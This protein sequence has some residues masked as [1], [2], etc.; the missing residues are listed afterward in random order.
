MTVYQER[1]FKGIREGVEEK[2]NRRDSVKVRD[3][4]LTRLRT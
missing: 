2:G 3:I 1:F 4:R